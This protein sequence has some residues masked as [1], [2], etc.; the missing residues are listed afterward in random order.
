M[1]LIE[2]ARAASRAKGTHLNDRYRQL[3]G[4]RG[5]EKAIIAIA[6]RSSAPAGSSSQPTSPNATP[7]PQTV[8][9]PA[10]STSATL[11]LASP[12]PPRRRRESWERRK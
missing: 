2:S 10:R 5:D 7:V 3:A 8:A 4:R 9:A 1:T 12:V 6:R 11:S